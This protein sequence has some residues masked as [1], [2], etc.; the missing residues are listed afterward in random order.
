MKSERRPT[1]PP[2]FA[3]VEIKRFGKVDAKGPV[4]G[5]R[6]TLDSSSLR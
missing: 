4:R 3:C 1:R 5:S 6:A 2:F